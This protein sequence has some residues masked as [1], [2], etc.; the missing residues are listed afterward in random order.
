MKGSKCML[1]WIPPLQWVP[2]IFSMYKLVGD[3]VILL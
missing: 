2:G 3:I 1:P